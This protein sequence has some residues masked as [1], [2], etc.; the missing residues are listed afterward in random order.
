MTIKKSLTILILTAFTLLIQGCS[1]DDGGGSVNE[2]DRQAMLQNIGNNMIV[3]AYDNLATEVGDL[4]SAINTFTNAPTEGNLQSARSAWEDAYTAWQYA[5]PFNF[6]PAD[7]DVGMLSVLISTWPV[8]VALVEQRIGNGDLAMNSLDRDTRGFLTIEYLLYEDSKPDTEIVADFIGEANAN[9]R[10]YLE[11]V[12]NDIDTKVGAVD[13]A[14]DT[15]IDTFVSNDGTS[16]GSSVSLLFN[17]FNR[18]F[19]LIKNFKIGLPAGTRPGQAGPAPET[20][21]A[22]YSGKSL[23]FALYSLEAAD[24]VWYGRG[25]DGMDGIGFEEYLASVPGG[26]ELVADTQSSWTSLMTVINS[27]PS[28]QPLSE[29]VV[30]NQQAVSDAYTALQQHTR[31]FKS[32]L[33]SR[34]GISIT[35]SSGDG[36]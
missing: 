15:Y 12:V 20:T 24:N 31:Y 17:E 18:H 36:D 7:T 34:I 8:D 35:Y 1:S 27:I 5:A 10:A 30:S 28:Q 14:W 4:R 11:A 19:E 9:R 2:F 22:Y 6:G 25:L 32:D 3:P 16:P 33:S 26:E 13:A 23:D 21:E 29:T